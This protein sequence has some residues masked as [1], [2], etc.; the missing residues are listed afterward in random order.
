MSNTYTT[1]NNNT[2][3]TPKIEVFFLRKSLSSS[4]SYQILALRVEGLIAVL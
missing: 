2:P 4:K 1:D 3:N